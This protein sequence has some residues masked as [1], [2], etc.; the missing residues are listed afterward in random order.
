MNWP[1]EDRWDALLRLAGARR[2][3][4]EWYHR[5]TQ[6]YGE[7]QRHF[8]EYEEQIR[9]EY[10][11]VPL[12]VFASKRVEILQRLL[13]R[14]QIFSVNVFRQKYEKQARKNLEESI[15]RLKKMAS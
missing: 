14:S 13:A 6:A 2:L 8:F 10:A 12:S 4:P 5:L 15:S 11:W 1:P 3:A 7:P 9:R